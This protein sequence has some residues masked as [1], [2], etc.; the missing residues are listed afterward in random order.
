VKLLT[1]ALL[2]LP[3]RV[4]ALPPPLDVVAEAP[5]FSE[6][7]RA[8]QSLTVLGTLTKR[9]THLEEVSWFVAYRI[10]EARLI[11]R[12]EILVDRDPS[13]VLALVHHCVSSIDS[14]ACSSTQTSILW[15]DP[16]DG[17]L[18]K[19]GIGF[20]EPRRTAPLVVTREEASVAAFG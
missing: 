13:S 11:D 12:G 17:H 6:P 18:Q 19:A 5:F 1:L 15:L 2:L 14:A 9:T 7:E 10:D 20:H 16:R 3:S 4:A 8:D